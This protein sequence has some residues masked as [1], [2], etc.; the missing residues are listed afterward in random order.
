VAT[1][2]TEL[3]TYLGLVLLGILVW[4]AMSPL[5]TLGWWAGWF[6]ERIYYDPIPPDGHV[7]SV[8]PNA[9]SYLIFLSGVG[10]VSGETISRREK[11]FLHRLAVNLPQTVVIDD[12][13]P[14]SVN[15]L[16]LTGQP[17]FA[18]I[19]R[20]AFRRKLHGPQLAGYLIN[21]RN[22]WQVMISVD[23]RY[24][25][26][27]NQAIAQ[28][29]L[30]SLLRYR[31]DP[32]G[33]EP[34]YIIGYSGG[35]QLAVGAAGYL[36]EWLPGPVYVISLGGIFGSEPSLLAVTHFYHLYGTGDRSHHLGLIAPGRWR[37]LAA[38]PWNRAKRQGLVTERVIGPMGH[39]GRGGY[40]DA[41]N[42]FPDGTPF[43]D[44]TV[45]AIVS[46]MHE[47]AP[48]SLPLTAPEAGS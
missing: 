26:I 25:P 2:F 7:R 29:F 42:T 36:R 3:L 11:E 43:V 4:A 24:G 32:A 20:W 23:K 1:T 12:V 16:A 9:S 34:V 33:N 19:W 15:N 45:Q 18:R 44:R 39:T 35:G 14:Y 10:R 30:H 6:G 17:F 22:I 48:Q 13:F 31:Y 47:T 27:F 21:L 28:T 46:I 37:L 38:S 40:L 41:K 5:E 8:R